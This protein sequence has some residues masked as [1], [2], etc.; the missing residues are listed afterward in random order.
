MKLLPAELVMAWNLQESVI[1][2]VLAHCVKRSTRQ[3]SDIAELE[4]V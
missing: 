4:I 1:E 3:T 2:K